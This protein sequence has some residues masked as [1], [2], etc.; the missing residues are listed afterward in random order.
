MSA[1]APQM[2]G[3]SIVWSTVWTDADQ[4]KHQS[5]VL[6]AFVRGIYRWP[7][8]I[9]IWLT[10]TP[11]SSMKTKGRHIDN[12]FV[13]GCTWGCPNDNFG[14]SQWRECCQYDDLL[15]S[16]FGLKSSASKT[17]TRRLSY[18]NRTTGDQKIPLAGLVT[19][20][21]FPYADVIM[22]SCGHNLH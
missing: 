6:L 15:V 13:T 9:Q 4:G 18:F 2:T 16:V 17:P 22:N 1:M 7:N 12:L 3:V 14:C 21:M 5:S 10:Y 11:R 19:R 8:L 20:E